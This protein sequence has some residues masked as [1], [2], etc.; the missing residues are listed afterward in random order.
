M[1]KVTVVMPVF[2]TKKI[3]LT[4]A[5]YSV[6]SQTLSNI[7]LII[8]DNGS[9]QETV[10]YLKYIADSNDNVRLFIEPYGR[11][12]RAR[13]V[14]IRYAEGDFVAFLDSDDWLSNNALE[15]LYNN[16]I[17][18][19]VDILKSDYVT[20][21]YPEERHARTRLSQYSGFYNKIFNVK[22]KP[23]FL[24]SFPYIWNG[25]YKRSFLTENNIYFHDEL[26]NQDLLFT[27]KANVLAKKILY[28]RYAGIFYRNYA[29]SE[30]KKIYDNCIDMLKI[31]DGIEEAL[32]AYNVF[33]SFKYYYINSKIKRFIYINKYV[34]CK[35]LSYSYFSSLKKTIDEVQIEEYFN[36]FN[37]EEIQLFL[38]IKSIS[39][40]CWNAYI[41]Y[42]HN[43]N[44]E[45][46]INLNV[47]RRYGR[48]LDEYL[49][50]LSERKVLWFIRRICG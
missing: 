5:I 10:D 42:I 32:R 6:L 44:S 40:D 37:R 29:Q 43:K 50:G 49:S 21:S 8:V 18:K 34:S 41:D 24:L 22:E 26:I 28:I 39:L 27:W 48:D 9:N 30:S 35:K 20:V 45:K 14:G 12:G 25:I 16:A 1:Y 17:G 15:I 2:N 19:D 36:R 33:D 7:E 13:N 11:Q 4:K 23:E 47:V 3:F 38:M 46:E 31:Y